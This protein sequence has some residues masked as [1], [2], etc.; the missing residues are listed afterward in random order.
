MQA[1]R[2]RQPRNQRVSWV[3]H[4]RQLLWTNAQQI[5]PQTIQT[6]VMMILGL[7][8]RQQALHTTPIHMHME[9]LQRA[10]SIQMR[11]LKKLPRKPIETTG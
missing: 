6:A 10:H 7:R 9:N 5:R 1:L 3:L 11:S 2:P 8:R 4:R